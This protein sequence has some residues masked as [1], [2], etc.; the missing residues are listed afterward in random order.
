MNLLVTPQQAE[1][2]S[3]AGGQMTMQLVLRNPLDTAV[4]V[5]PGITL[6]SIF[7]GQPPPVVHSLQVSH[8]RSLA[9]NAT[10]GFRGCRNGTP[11]RPQLARPDG[12]H[13][14]QQSNRNKDAER[15]VAR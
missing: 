3:L 7:S 2:L 1:M 15:M 5:I 11:H 10:P 6:S 4:I 14:G 13:L 12:D 9:V 8:A